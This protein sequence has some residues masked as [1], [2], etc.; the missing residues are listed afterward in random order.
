VVTALGNR[1]DRPSLANFCFRSSGTALFEFF[2]G[3]VGPGD[4]TTPGVYVFTGDIKLGFDASGAV[5]AFS[6]TG[7]MDDVCAMIA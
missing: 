3:D 5:V 1:V 6:S 2:P 4:Q 7:T